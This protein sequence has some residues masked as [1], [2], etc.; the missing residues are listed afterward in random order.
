MYK[1]LFFLFIICFSCSC[2]KTNNIPDTII[3]DLAIV[4][5]T[6]PAT[7]TLGN[8]I[9]STVKCSGS[10]LCYRFLNFEIKQIANT[11]FEV[12]AKGTC[13]NAAKGDVICLQAIYYKDTIFKIT[14]SLKG[15]YIIQF[16]NQT[17]LFKTD[18]V[19]V[20]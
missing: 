9:T 18:T 20:N 19:Q 13:P 6:T 12:R 11:K 4:N 15:Q 1:I 10:D 7:Q 5:T 17:S 14:P 2:K 16:Y 8:D 3:T